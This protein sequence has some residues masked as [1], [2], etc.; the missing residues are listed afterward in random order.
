[1]VDEHHKAKNRKNPQQ[2]H[3]WVINNLNT[4]A[5]Y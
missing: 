1:M 5:S 4:A 2:S 3:E